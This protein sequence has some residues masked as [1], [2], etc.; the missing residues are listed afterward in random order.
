VGA[1]RVRRSRVSGW[2]RDGDVEMDTVH[3][4]ADALLEGIQRSLLC[5]VLLVE[6]FRQ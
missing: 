5:G 6:C 3:R 2:R 4:F 1:G